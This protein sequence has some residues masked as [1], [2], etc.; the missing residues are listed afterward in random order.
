[1]KEGLN[2]VVVGAGPAGIAAIG[3]L[4]DANIPLNKIAWID[5]VFKVGDFG[6][7]WKHVNSNT[8]IE[9]FIKFYN[10]FD[11]FEFAS[12]RK[13]FLIEHAKPEGTCPLMIAAEP[14]QWIT[15]K[16]RNK[17]LSICDKV[18]ELHYSKTGWQLHLAS[19]LQLSTQKVILALGAQ[20]IKLPY[21]DLIHIPL[22]TAM[23]PELLKQAINTNDTIA[24]FGSYQSA[25]TVAENLATTNTLKV[26][27]FYRSQRSFDQNVASLTLSPHIEFYPITPLN[28]ITH[29]PRCNKAIYAVGFKR[30]K[31]KI[32]GLADDFLYDSQTGMIAPG[33]YGLG[34]AFPETIPYTMGRLNYNVSAIWPFIKY[35]KRVFPMWQNEKV[36]SLSDRKYAE[37]QEVE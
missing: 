24:V 1:M 25:R 5:P 13:K 7:A 15:H 3:K 30:R 29:I 14:L 23:N 26:I 32:R 18:L 28:L 2:W 33:V 21:P 4:I 31:I 27:H 8:N 35:L 9:S 6:T 20:A 22:K 36:F 37:L 34:I 16:L 11:A 10:A 17:V 12:D 19:G